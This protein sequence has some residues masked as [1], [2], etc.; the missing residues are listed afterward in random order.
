MYTRWLIALLSYFL[1]H[2]AATEEVIFRVA[3]LH[4]D[5]RLVHDGYSETN[6]TMCSSFS[7]PPLSGLAQCCQIHPPGWHVVPAIFLRNGLPCLKWLERQP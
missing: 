6:P 3:S 4:D 5:G 1:C 2:M 7:H